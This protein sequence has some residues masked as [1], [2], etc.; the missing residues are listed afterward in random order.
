MMHPAFRSVSVFAGAILVVLI[1]GCSEPVQVPSQPSTR[2]ARTRSR[3]PTGV[4]TVAAWADGRYQ[5]VVDALYDEEHKPDPCILRLVRAYLEENSQVYV[6]G[7][8]EC[9]VLDVENLSF[10]KYPITQIPGQ[11]KSVFDRLQNGTTDK[12]VRVLPIINP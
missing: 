12:R 6:R 5:I 2:Q 1:S 9:V 3:Y 7:K 4:D 10:K 8:N 11:Y